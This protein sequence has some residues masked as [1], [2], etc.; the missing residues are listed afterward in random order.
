MAWNE[1]KSSPE[2]NARPSPERTTARTDGSAATE[3]PA[4]AMATNIA[5]SRAF[6]LSERF[7]RTWATPS[8]PSICTLWHI[9]ALPSVG[10]IGSLRYHSG[11]PGNVALGQR[12]VGDLGP[13]HPVHDPA[14]GP[15]ARPQEEQP[16]RAAV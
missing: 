7:S 4:S 6:I 8:A 14:S 16:P 9:S 12:S 11:R 2:Q 3:A 13:Q 15:V 1:L 10:H 5:P